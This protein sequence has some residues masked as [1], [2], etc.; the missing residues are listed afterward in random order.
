MD[1]KFKFAIEKTLEHEG[2]YVNDP[3]DPGGETNF[4]ISKRSYPNVD[5]KNLTRDEA[6]KIYYRDWWLKY[7][8][9]EIE[10]AIVAAKVFDL[11]V[12][13]GPKR[14]HELLQHALRESSVSS[15][16]RFI[17]VDG[18]IG[19]VTL[20][21]INNHSSPGYLLKS[22]KL[23]AIKYYAGLRK[24]KYLAGWIKRALA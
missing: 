6:V 2:G 9:G 11:A 24:P 1:K 3:A 22:L 15:P 17:D 21:A 8:Y 4:G 18:I 5:I 20:S 14:A 23:E 7:R 10:W 12:N 19:D 13:M 16:G